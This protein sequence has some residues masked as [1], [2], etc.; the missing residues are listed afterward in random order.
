MPATFPKHGAIYAKELADDLAGQGFSEAEIFKGSGLTAAALEPDKPVTG[1]DRIAAFFEH[2][3]QLTGDG[4]LGFNRG[5]IRE[6][7]S[8]GLISYVGVSS[9]TVLDLIQNIARYRRVFS[10]A[11][12]LDSGTL[13]VDGVLKWHFGIP[14]QINHRQF[15]EF[16]ISGLMHAMRQAAANDFCPE[17][18][19]FSHARNANTDKFEQY[20]GCDVQ[21][22]ARDNSCRFRA[23]DLALPLAT[24]DDELYKV[25]RNCCEQSLQDKSHNTPL[26]IVEVERAISDR[27]TKGEVTQDDVARALGMSARTLSRRLADEGTTFFQTLE[28]L[29]KALAMNY[30]R[31]SD[32]TLAEIGFLLGYASLSSLNHAFK[33][34]T[35]QTPGQFRDT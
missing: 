6:M 14:T 15:S 7:R 30:L 2:A 29:R 23:K 25:L 24:A 18:V 19:T 32:L 31:D 35:G 33:R 10:D 13:D 28:G 16:G 8:S 26:L 5:Q 3:A 12:E 1:F 17:L 20:F 27:L 21:F 9:P 4:I 11:L 34:W 22:G